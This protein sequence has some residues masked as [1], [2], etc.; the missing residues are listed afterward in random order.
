[1]PAMNYLSFII[2]II[3]QTLVVGWIT[4]RV[5]GILIREMSLRF[6]HA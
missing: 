4:S 1:M 3:T 5:I 2:V 6:H